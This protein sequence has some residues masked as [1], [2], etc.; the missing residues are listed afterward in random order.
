MAY[1]RCG[2]IDGGKTTGYAYGQLG[3]GGNIRK[4]TYTP[5]GP[6]YTDGA[7]L[8]KN[9]TNIIVRKNCTVLMHAWVHGAGDLY[10]TTGSVY[11]SGLTNAVDGAKYVF[12]PINLTAGTVLRVGSITFEGEGARSPLLKFSMSVLS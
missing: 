7:I 6:I 1:Y 2:M 4:G 3:Y 9:G 5:S 11:G 10:P 8:D 12:K